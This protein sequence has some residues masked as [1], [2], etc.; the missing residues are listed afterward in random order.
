MKKM[1]VV[2]LALALFCFILGSCAHEVITY[3]P[4]CGKKSIKEVSVYKMDTGITEIFYQCE[5]TSCGKK[6]GAGQMSKAA[7]D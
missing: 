7:A 4:F 5:N 1:R 3:C 6:F 2:M